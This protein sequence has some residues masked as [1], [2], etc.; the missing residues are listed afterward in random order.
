MKRSTQMLSRAERPQH[1]ARE[2]R[3]A[4]C[5]HH[6]RN[7]RREAWTRTGRRT[8]REGRAKT[9]EEVE[10]AEGV[11]VNVEGEVDIEAGAAADKLSPRRPASSTSR[12]S[13]HGLSKMT[14]F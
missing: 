6:L 5:S 11:Q 3:I 2:T 4:D 13:S 1:T 9:K 8:P 10:D 14:A 12:T 7:T